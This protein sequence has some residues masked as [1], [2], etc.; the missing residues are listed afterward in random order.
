MRVTQ[1]WVE[2]ERLLQGRCRRI[3]AAGTVARE[4]KLVM[5]PGIP[6]IK[7]DVGL[8][9]LDGPIGPVER[10]V[11]VA[12]QLDGKQGARVQIDRVP[13]IAKGRLKFVLVLVHGATFEVGQHRIG[14]QC[15]RARISL[16]GLKVA[17]G[18]HGLIAFRNPPPE[19]PFVGQG[20]IGKGPGHAGYGHYHHR[21]QGSA[22]GND[23]SKSEGTF[24]VGRFLKLIH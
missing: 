10:G 12:E 4:S 23:G 3:D 5:N 21:H 24:G 20:G 7:V 2:L 11:D 13:K 19:L 6:L 15:H 17:L 18:G 9:A 22:H 8:V 16:N 1:G 14:L